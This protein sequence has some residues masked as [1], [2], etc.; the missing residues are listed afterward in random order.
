MHGLIF[1]G[2]S[3]ITVTAEDFGGNTAADMVVVWFEPIKGEA[4]LLI[5]TPTEFRAPLLWLK[6]WKDISGIPAGIISLESIDSDPRFSSSHDLPEKI[7]RT[8]AHGYENHGT[9]YVMLV[10]DVDKFPVHYTKL[11][12][13][14]VSWGVCWAPSDLYFADLY[15]STGQFN[16]WDANQNDIFGE[17]GD[18]IQEGVELPDFAAINIDGC[19]Q[20]LTDCAG[21]CVD[22]DSDPTH[23]GGC[24][25]ACPEGETCQAG[26]CQADRKDAREVPGDSSGC[27]CSAAPGRK[28]PAMFLLALALLL[29]YRRGSR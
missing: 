27:G 26:V 19:D 14:G 12:R 7:K 3:E 9:R 11:G 17:W 24:Y 25:L 28:I 20:G 13:Q 8:I 15:D 6:A 4:E 1:D 16:D 21:T 29:G 23:C 10:G 18:A 2:R 5:L 22:L